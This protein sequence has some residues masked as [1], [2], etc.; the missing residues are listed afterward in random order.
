MRRVLAS[1][2][3]FADELRAIGIPVSMVE[4]IDA[5]SALEHTDLTNPVNLRAALGATLIQEGRFAEASRPHIATCG[6]MG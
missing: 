4:V 2:T 5:A 6:Y 1:L 3:D